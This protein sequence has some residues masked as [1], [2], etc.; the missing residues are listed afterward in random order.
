LEVIKSF[1]YALRGIGYILRLERNARIHLVIA[2]IVLLAGVLL[3]LSVLELAAIFFAILTVFLAE[4]ANTAL[5]KTLDLIK[6]QPHENIRMVKDM[7]A[8][9]VLVAAIGAAAIG[10]VIFW[11]Y[12]TEAVWRPVL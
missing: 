10:A 5:E 4:I 7:A 12:I 3:K 2:I 11:P 6:P 9:A 1:H 8:G